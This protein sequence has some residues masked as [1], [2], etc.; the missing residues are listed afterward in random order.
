MRKS[1]KEKK[2]ILKSFRLPHSFCQALLALS[3]RDMRTQ[4]GMLEVIMRDYLTRLPFEVTEP[5][6]RTA[7]KKATRRR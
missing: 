5:H 2:A 6:E 4:S 1:T 3:D 7:A